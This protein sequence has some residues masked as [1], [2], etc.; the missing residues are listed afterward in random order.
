MYKIY[1]RIHQSMFKCAAV[2]LPWRR[3]ELLE[4]MSALAVQLRLE[5]V[6]RV[7]IVS[8]EKLISLGLHNKLIEML[9]FAG[10]HYY[11][12][13]KTDA[14]PTI[15]N[16][17]EAL[18]LYYKENCGGIIAFGGGSPID[19]AKGVGAR[20]ARPKKNISEM[21]GLLK[22]HKRI[23]LL[24]AIPT[25]AGTG[26]ETTLAAVITDSDTHEKYA[27]NDPALVPRYAVLDPSLTI[28]LPPHI[29]AATGMD[30]LTHAV[31]AYIGLSNTAQ[32]KK[33]A[34]AAVKLIFNNLY[35]AYCVG[36][37]ID[38]RKNMQNAAY[39]AGA[40]FTHAYVGNVHAVAHTLGG[41]YGTPHGLANAV[42]LP[43]VLN[44][45]GSRIYK[46]LAELAVAAGI[47][48]SAR[49]EK[50]NAEKFITAIRALNAK[51]NIPEKI[52]D[53][54]WEDIPML[55]YRAR[56]EANPFY[57][58]P[59]IFNQIEMEAVY[60]SIIGEKL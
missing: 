33:D 53:L 16:I 9:D 60:L 39:L 42:I 24:A 32:T 31:E 38:A 30:A 44:M 36:E 10:I 40:A 46:H 21:K 25:T 43:Y 29:T 3:P 45:Y 20:V 19:C 22:I 52:A 12:Y 54:K 51:M 48:D 50:E 34:Q 13:D 18:C 47:S 4:D 26:S 23:P 35:P 8:D 41:Q 56:K 59:K 37:N 14:N 5:G 15:Q 1:C 57:P 49:T 7:L 17:E 55:A 58:V 6:D 2:F 11:I 27:V 28:N